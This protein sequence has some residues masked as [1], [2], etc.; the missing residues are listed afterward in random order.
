[1]LIVTHTAKGHL[2][3]K[4]ALVSSEIVSVQLLIPCPSSRAVIE[5]AFEGIEGCCIRVRGDDEIKFL[6][7]QVR[8][9][10]CQR[11]R[12]SATCHWT[13]RCR[14]SGRQRLT[15]TR[16]QVVKL[17][18]DIVAARPLVD[19]GNRHDTGRRRRIHRAGRVGINQR[20]QGS[21]Q[22]GHRLTGQ[23]WQRVAYAP[24][25]QVHRS[26]DR[27]RR[28]KGDRTD[29][30]QC[31]RIVRE[32]QVPYLAERIVHAVRCCHQCQHRILTASDC[33]IRHALGNDRDIGYG[34]ASGR[35][36]A[37]NQCTLIGL[38]AVSPRVVHL[39]VKQ[40]YP[41][42]GRDIFKREGHSLLRFF[43]AAVSAIADFSA[44]ATTTTS[45]S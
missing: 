36:L 4:C 41:D 37:N 40:G 39:G 35:D 31:G 16:A 28:Q 21:G 30:G 24:D 45:L 33:C 19:S 14:Q 32:R 15:T 38:C 2:R 5:Q 26:V 1:M 23:G 18:V 8:Q 7:T 34:R 42:I 9:G 12:C 25:V 3:A 11:G 43:V 17:Q 13:Q 10:H 44:T 20:G 6:A 29:S 27:G 22:L